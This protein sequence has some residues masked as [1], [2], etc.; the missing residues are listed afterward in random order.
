MNEPHVDDGARSRER[1]TGR[2]RDRSA[3]MSAEDFRAFTR[4]FVA[5]VLSGAGFR[6]HGLNR[7][8]RERGGL[9][10]EFAVAARGNR[11]GDPSWGFTFD[12]AIGPPQPPDV[13]A[14]AV[15]FGYLK[16][17]HDTWY[18]LDHDNHAALGDAVR[19][20]IQR[21]ALP[22]F[23]GVR[24]PAALA[25]LQAL[26]A[27]GAPS[28]LPAALRELLPGIGRDFAAEYEALW[29]ETV[30]PLL[31]AAGFVENDGVVFRSGEEV[32]QAFGFR[33]WMTQDR[34]FLDLE[35]I[36]GFHV[37][38]TGE[39]VPPFQVGSP[40]WLCLSSGYVLTGESRHFSRY[41]L[42]KSTPTRLADLLREDI[43][44]GLLPFFDRHRDAGAVAHARRE[45]DRYRERR[46]RRD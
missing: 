43:V 15:R 30:M 36:L 5:P 45:A 14:F 16:A 20:D 42:A 19:L 34:T 25:R 26:A 44:T 18:H 46:E 2:P 12:I 31:G 29:R 8:L 22:L 17:G 38:S 41:Q 24:D 7:Y 21:F 32:T 40:G 23:D 28:D 4:E 11:K 27:A 9:L 35:G 33:T 1:V 6:S 3:G 13:S 10:Q 37:T 39:E